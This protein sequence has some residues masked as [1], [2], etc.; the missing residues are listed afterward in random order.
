MHDFPLTSEYPSYKH[1]IYGIYSGIEKRV[2]VTSG[3]ALARERN[4]SAIR[5]F[6]SLRI[7]MM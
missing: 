7:R 5:N 6:S 1:G 3:L 2:P 4:S